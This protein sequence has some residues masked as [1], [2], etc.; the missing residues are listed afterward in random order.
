MIS[1]SIALGILALFSALAIPVLQANPSGEQVIAGDVDISRAGSTLTV[2]QGS[3]RAI[4]NWQDFSIG[5][6]QLTQFVQPSANSAALNRVTGSNVSSIYGTLQANGQIYLINPN[7]IAI[8]PTGVIN[9]QSFIASTLDVTNEEFLA[10]GDMTF[11]HSHPRA[12]VQIVNLG[13]ISADGGDIVLI[14]Q[15]IDNRGSLNAGRTVGLAAGSEV[16]LT[17]TGDERLFIQAGS[18]AGSVQNSGLIEATMAE[19][20]AAGGNE[21]ALAINNT[22]LVRA[23]G[24]E[25]VGGRII[26]RADGGVVKNEGEIIASDTTGDVGGTVQVSAEEIV[27]A[28]DSLIDASG[29]ESGGSITIGGEFRGEA[30]G[31]APNAESVVVEEDAQLYADGGEGRIILWS[32]GTTVFEGAIFAGGQ[33][34]VEVSGKQ[35]LHFAGTVDTDGGT[36]WLDPFDYIIDAIAAGNIVTALGSNNV[37]IN[38]N[39][40]DGTQGSQGVGTADGDITVN[41]DMFYDSAFDL[42]FLAIGDVQ[43]NASVQNRAETGGGDINVVSGWDGTTAFDAT[44]FLAEDVISTTLFGTGGTSIQLGD[45]SQAVA[46]AVGSRSGDT[47]VFG[48][49]VNLQA[50]NGSGMG[51]FAQIG[52]N[53]TDQGAAY[54]ITGD[55]N[56]RATNDITATGGD[57]TSYV[58]AQIGHVGADI[59]PDPGIE[60]SVDADISITAGN[61]ITFRAG[62]GFFAYAQVG[63]GGR[64]AW[65]DFQGE[66]LISHAN[67]VTFAAGGIN[68]T[69]AQLG[70]GGVLAVGNHS[71]TITINEAGD[72]NFEGGSDFSAYAQLG[73][74]G[75]EADGNHNGDITITQAG[76]LMFIGGID[77]QTYAQLGHGGPNVT[78][79]LSGTIT[80]TNA[81]DLIFTSGT[82]FNAYAQL[83]HGGFSADGTF[84]GGIDVTANGSV[85]LTGAGGADRYARIGHGDQ[86][87]NG[88]TNTVSGD[89]R[90]VVA[91]DLSLNDA[92]TQIGHQTDA[93]T[94]T[95]GDTVIGVG[96]T[97][98]AA[99]GSRLDSATNVAAGDSAG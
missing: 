77:I 42:T 21:Y 70:H 15:E 90:L 10:G 64:G 88:D 23:T 71:G 45:G 85:N 1:R 67:E 73:H 80:I 65:G 4:I 82:G 11:R 37:V 24:A 83:G 53:A 41:S 68:D 86:V 54:S 2:N 32:D 36:L 48:Y 46:V 92:N 29:T 20:K 63:H 6:G 35:F 95:S 74:G 39:L 97:F 79:N 49:D 17:T 61:D 91:S 96:R 76:A 58:Y 9:T 19:L 59:D 47:N 12:N 14:A 87:G 38:T 18:R 81:T 78:G 62:N 16:L 44:T 69:Y 30:V 27:L 66:I 52:F 28:A 33:G 93:G 60:A 57:T 72:L 5:A 40:D 8:G 84:A 89:I 22:G 99:A 26:L 43:F 31:D 98:T 56:V 51:R 7:G 13:S 75:R 50:K 55:I 34:F 25:K 94:Y 3:D